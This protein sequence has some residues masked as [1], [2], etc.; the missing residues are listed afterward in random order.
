ML[1]HFKTKTK[2]FIVDPGVALYDQCGGK[3]WTGSKKCAPSLKCYARTEHYSNV[4][5][6][7]SRSL[8]D[9][10]NIFFF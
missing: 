1:R 8:A 7:T 6:E 5:E 9:F 2:T 4:S 10:K 3:D